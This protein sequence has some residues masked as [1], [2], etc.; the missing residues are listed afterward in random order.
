MK[1][2][3]I[4]FFAVLLGFISSANAQHQDYSREMNELNNRIEKYFY[5]KGTNYYREMGQA[6]ARQRKVSYL[7]P[8]CAMFEATH[9]MGKL[10]GDF[11]TFENV[12]RIISKYHNNQ[13]PAP[14]YA[15]YSEEFGG[16]E[17]FYDDNQWIG[18]TAMDAWK[19]TGKKQW[20]DTGKEI[21]RFMMTGFDTASGGGLYWKEK[22]YSTKNTCSNGPGIILALQ[23]YQATH[24]KPYLDTA[25]LL[26][27]WVNKHLQ[28][29]E[30]LYLD[31]LKLKTGIA[32]K[33][34]YSY[35]SGTMMQ[36]NLY[37]FEITGDK[38]YLTEAVR[39]G[40]ASAKHFY[41]NGSFI[42][43]Y[44]FN[45]VLLRAY[46]HLLKYDQDPT[47][48]SAFRVALDHAL[49]ADKNERGLMGV[50]KEQN[51]VGQGGL[52]EILARFAFMQKKGMI[53]GN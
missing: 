23:L 14:G 18:I 39:I 26:Y 21:Y 43:N 47:M 32:D 31:N 49:T 53:P 40:K 15:S 52:L 2:R 1:Q 11:N 50:K 35:N 46:Q 12:F 13:P 51:L 45:A 44:W 3:T 22:D 27:N 10:T 7:W 17:R 19:A 48:I 28:T 33:R 6:E 24:E 34:I 29:P 30:G 41:G 8:L 5:K 9:E 37:F 38:K 20:M 42:D 16:G 4:Y 25:I 36:S